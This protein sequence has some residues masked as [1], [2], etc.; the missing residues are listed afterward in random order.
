MVT[1]AKWLRRFMNIWPPFVG[2]GI[3]VT[4][5]DDDFRRAQVRM[6]LRWYNRNYMGTQYGGSLYSMTDAFYAIMIIRNLDKK[7]FVWDKSARIEYIAPARNTVV[8]DYRLDDNMIETIRKNT[9]QGQKF[10]YDIP[11]N[12][13]DQDNTLIARV[14]K[15]IYI[16]KKPEFR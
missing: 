11:V 7:Y 16:R 1:Q 13:H 10:L 12:I 2:A 14:N 4:R 5:I 6:K 3:S 15:V 9:D 8:A